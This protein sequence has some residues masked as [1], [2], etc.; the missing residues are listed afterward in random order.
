MRG[1]EG[2]REEV[3]GS[4]RDR[5]TERQ[6]DREKEE[7]ERERE[8][9]RATKLTLMVYRKKKISRPSS[10]DGTLLGHPKSAGNGAACGHAHASHGTLRHAT[11]L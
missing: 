9:A 8:R 7:E 4:D 1:R 3:R 11:T 5:E 6:R 2:G 10:A